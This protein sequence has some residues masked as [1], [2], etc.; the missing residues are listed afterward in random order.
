MT[1]EKKFIISKLNELEGYVKELD[2]LLERDDAVI[3]KNVETLRA[4][5]RDFQLA[6][7]TML[8]INQY[9]IKELGLPVSDD[10]Q[11]TFYALGENAILS[12][13]F[14][15]KLAPIAGLRNRLVHRYEA[16]NNKQF[17]EDLRKNFSD[18]R[19][20]EKVILN[21]AESKK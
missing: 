6:V 8:D 21:Y 17:L 12:K 18:F 11:S 19:N 10:F 4:A 1:F 7:D 13:E 2:M 9:F 14:A 5:E 16:V 15:V 20:Y 3:L